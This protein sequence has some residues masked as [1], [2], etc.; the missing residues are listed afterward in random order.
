MFYVYI[1]QS[2]KSGV[3]YIGCTDD[4]ERRII[5]HNSGKVRSTKAYK[6][7]LLRY[8]AKYNTLS[9]ARRREAQIKKW[10]SRLAIE[11]LTKH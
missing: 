5:Q 6:P 4:V 10:K 3:Y 9:E 8:K 11:R 1:L 7:W 2:N